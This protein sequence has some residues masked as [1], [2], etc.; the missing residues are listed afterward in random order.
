[1]IALL[2]ALAFQCPDGSPPPCNRP[3]RTAVT[4][5]NPSSVAVLY[6]ETVSRDTTDMQ[7][8]VGL[9]EEL[10]TRLSQVERLEVKSRYESRRV[11]GS[12][13][14]PRAIGRTLRAAYLVSGSLQQAGS[15]VRLNVSLVRSATGAQVWGEI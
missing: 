14:D 2:A 11:R 9:T 8:A 12:D 6:F 10:I 15:R 1:M 5:L 13:E 4:A 7:L 3:A